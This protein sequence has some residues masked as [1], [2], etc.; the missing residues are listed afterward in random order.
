MCNAG[1]CPQP[2]YSYCWPP[3]L[4]MAGLSKFIP[5]ELHCWLHKG[6]TGA[7]GGTQA[8][9]GNAFWRTVGSWVSLGQS[10]QKCWTC[11][12]TQ[13][14]RISFSACAGVRSES[15]ML[16]WYGPRLLACSD[17]IDEVKCSVI[18][19]YLPGFWSEPDLCLSGNVC[20]VINMLLYNHAYT[21]YVI[22]IL[23][24]VNLQAIYTS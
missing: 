17:K 11:V 2:T 23:L 18:L 19:M 12:L 4:P 8:P 22:W 21:D 3:S 1:L 10:F 5:T 15:T 9:H 6:Q 24:T 13:T 20:R 7:W 14:S 16:G